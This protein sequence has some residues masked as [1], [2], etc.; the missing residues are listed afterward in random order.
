MISPDVHKIVVLDNYKLHLTFKNGEERIFDVKPYIDMGRVFAPLANYSEFRQVSSENGGA[1]WE[2]GADLSPDTL[3]IR[4]ELI[5]GMEV[6]NKKSL[7]G[8]LQQYANSSLIEKEKEAYAGAAAEKESIRLRDKNRIRP[9]LEKLE[10]LWLEFPDW[11]FAQVV[12]ALQGKAD[13]DIFFME[14]SELFEVIEKILKEGQDGR[15]E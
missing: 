10:E 3:Y 15:M 4:G 9:F 8:V 2:C 13:R 1:E 7:R 6:K 5:D 12:S 14:E 11:R